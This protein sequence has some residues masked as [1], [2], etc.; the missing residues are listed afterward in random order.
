MEEG[1]KVIF[2][3]AHGLLEFFV[4]MEISLVYDPGYTYIY[5]VKSIG[6]NS[7]TSNPL[8]C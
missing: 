6:L 4:L 8:Y 5:F 1:V 7:W 3:A 2:L